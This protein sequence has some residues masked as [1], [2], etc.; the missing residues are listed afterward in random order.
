[1]SRVP[2][3]STL[4]LLLLAGGAHAQN[5][6]VLLSRGLK[7]ALGQKREAGERVLIRALEALGA[8]DP[9]PLPS[10]S[11]RRAPRATSFLFG[12]V[13]A[14]PSL[15]PVAPASGPVPPRARIAVLVALAKTRW[16][17]DK[18]VEGYATL[19]AALEVAEAA[20]PENHPELAELHDLGRM[21]ASAADADREAEMHARRR[22]E[23]CR[24]VWG[25]ASP[26]T[27]EALDDLASFLD[28]RRRHRDRRKVLLQ[29]LDVWTQVYGPYSEQRALVLA[30]LADVALDL[31]EPRTADGLFDQLLDLWDRLGA[32]A[33]YALS[34][35]G[36]K[37]GDSLKKRGR[38]AEAEAAVRRAAEI[39]ARHK[40]VTVEAEG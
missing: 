33:R 39:E 24:V 30:E 25:N 1:M 9:A 27:G 37:W 8:P 36:K 32:P 21:M 35:A 17:G 23:V 22:V 10:S 4:A 11:P 15:P 5:W 7:L 13:E 2:L 19:K 16:W 28:P 20:L 6:Q 18:D 40:V 38:D 31:D 26:E 12:P 14:D 29:S 3:V 34:N